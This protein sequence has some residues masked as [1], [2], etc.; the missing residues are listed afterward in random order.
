T[1]TMPRPGD[2]LSV[3]TAPRLAFGVI[4]DIQFADAEDG[5][6]FGGCRLRLLREA[7]REWADESPPVDFVLQLGDS[8]DGQNARR[9]EAESALQQVLEVLGQLS[10]PV[11][12]AWGN[13]ELYNFSRARLVQTGL[14]SR[15]GGSAGPADTE[16][17]AYHCSPGPRLRLV[18]L[19]AYDTSILGTDRGSPR[20]QEALRLLREKNP[21]D[22]LN[23]PEGT[24]G[25]AEAWAA[26]PSLS[27]A[28]GADSGMPGAQACAPLLPPPPPPC[29]QC[30][31][32]RA[33]EMLLR[34]P[35][36]EL[37]CALCPA[38]PSTTQLLGKWLLQSTELCPP[39]PMPG[40]TPNSGNPVFVV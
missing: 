22:D 17:H 29:R 39:C 14:Y 8:I 34:A 37:C 15:A 24:S 9:G 27:G 2:E 30:G 32:R 35:G 18:V 11:H 26:E 20:Y 4:A 36:L 12:H 1:A 5:Y 28:P 3:L 19:D 38:V 10:V 40:G 21:N 6:D 25:L 13:H 23:N 7:V 31:R 33:Q 16:C